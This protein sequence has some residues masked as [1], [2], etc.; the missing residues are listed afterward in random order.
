VKR[1]F[2]QT[3]ISVLISDI[4]TQR[5]VSKDQRR[6][7]F[8]R[9]IAASIAEV[10]VIEPLVVFSQP[11]GRYM[12]LDGHI[13]LLILK[14]MGTQMVQCIV[15]T[16]DEA[17]T[18]N[19]RVN[20][21]PPVIQHLMLLK[22]LDS[23]LSEERVAATLKVNISIIRRQRNM[24]T[25]VCKEAIEILQTKQVSAATFSLLKRMKPIRQ[26]EAAEHM[27]ISATYSSTFVRALLYATKSDLLI[28]LPRK[29][30]STDLEETTR[31]QFAKEGEALLKDLRSL[32]SDL[33]AEMLT[34]T[35]YQGYIGKLLSNQRVNRYL[36][37]KHPEILNVLSN[38]TSTNL[39]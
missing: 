21:I 2:A 30:A 5:V 1:A 39:Q 22:A 35:V 9:Q 11:A 3:S 8:F 15:S 25:G 24:L 13:R 6:A 23:G 12:L 17:Y 14:N 37:R 10:G 16:D 28:S 33:G 7:V 29:T 38:I 31:V 4:D 26:M 20:S 36:H 19:R 34:L 27:V 32:E 18:Y